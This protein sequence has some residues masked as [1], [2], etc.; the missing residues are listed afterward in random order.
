MR[1]SPCLLATCSGP[2]T[3]TGSLRA[4]L[5]Q[6]KEPL[7]SGQ[8]TAPS[9]EHIHTWRCICALC[10][11]CPEQ[12]LSEV[13]LPGKAML[14]TMV[15]LQAVSAIQDQSRVLSPGFW[16]MTIPRPGEVASLLRTLKALY[17]LKTPASLTR[18][19]PPHA[20]SPKARS[21]WQS[22]VPPTAHCH[23][24]VPIRVGSLSLA[25]S[26]LRAVSPHQQCWG[27]E[28]QHGGD[29]ELSSTATVLGILLEDEE[30]ASEGPAGTRKDREPIP[31]MFSP[32]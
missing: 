23:P 9:W 3:A 24:G 21:A 7:L 1:S 14:P 2:W 17:W 18:Q 29:R 31:S 5:P 11:R 32:P 25:V 19:G 4:A 28:E 16:M 30:K 20:H 12:V 13:Q 6:G 15:G 10:W 22:P 27:Q 8:H 26:P